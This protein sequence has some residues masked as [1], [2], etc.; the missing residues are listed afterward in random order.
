M[1]VH[2]ARS[3]EPFRS[4]RSCGFHSKEVNVLFTDVPSRWIHRRAAVS[5]E[6]ALQIK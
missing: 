4:T 2:G 1:C 6:T 3:Y 5:A